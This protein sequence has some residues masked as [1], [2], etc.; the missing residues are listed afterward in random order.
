MGHL[1]ECRTIL[2]FIQIVDVLA[3]VL[4][5]GSN[6]RTQDVEGEV[7]RKNVYGIAKIPNH[8]DQR[9]SALA[10]IS[11][12]QILIPLLLSKF[13]RAPPWNESHS[14]VFPAALPATL[15]SSNLLSRNSSVSLKSVDRSV[16][17]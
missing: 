15:N 2:S 1:Y 17:W 10:S 11:C 7:V 9:S 6:R 13:T 16:V 3:K 14:T 4:M 5:I 12:V 8:L